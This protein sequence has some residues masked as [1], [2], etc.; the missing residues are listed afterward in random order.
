MD[1]KIGLYN[2]K[3][4]ISACC[5]KTVK[6]YAVR[7]PMIMCQGCKHIIKCFLEPAAFQNYVTFCHSR[8]RHIVTDKV[9][10]YHVVVFKAYAPTSAYSSVAKEHA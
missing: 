4:R 1:D 6:I 10:P 8:G 9:G 2:D 7:N 3:Y 5:F